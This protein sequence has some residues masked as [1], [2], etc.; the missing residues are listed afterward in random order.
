MPTVD[1]GII[2]SKN[3]ALKKSSSILKHA[4]AERR[5]ANEWHLMARPGGLH[6]WGHYRDE[7]A[8][9]HTYLRPKCPWF[10]QPRR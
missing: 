3:E 9:K 4:T 1:R 10:P 5:G 6:M 8:P 2:W 7:W